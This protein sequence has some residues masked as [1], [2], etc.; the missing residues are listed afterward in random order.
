MFDYP[1][2]LP[3]ASQY[4]LFDSQ[5]EYDCDE[6][7]YRKN[8]VIKRLETEKKELIQEIQG[9]YEKNA[10]LGSLPK[11]F[12]DLKALEAKGKEADE[13]ALGELRATIVSLEQLAEKNSPGFGKRR[14]RVEEID[15]RISKMNSSDLSKESV[16]SDYDEE[17]PPFSLMQFESY[18]FTEMNQSK[19]LFFLLRK[20][21]TDYFAAQGEEAG[22]PNE[23]QRTDFT[24]DYY[25]NE[26][27]DN[28]GGKRNG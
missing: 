1:L 25:Y 10:E 27:L 2:Q 26:I 13:K 15:E 12:D 24:E 14:R 5:P 22:Y 17:T 6:I 18:P 4:S 28:R 7:E 9:V 23:M 19:T 16:K 20:E 21:L 3:D 11:L 8:Q